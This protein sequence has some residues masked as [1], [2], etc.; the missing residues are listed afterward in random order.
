MIALVTTLAFAQEV[1]TVDE[2][3]LDRYA[4]TWYELAHFPEWFQR[5]C[6]ATTATYTVR[7]DGLLDVE[8]RCRRGSLEGRETVAYGVAR[9]PDPEE[10]GKLEV[11]FFRPIWSDY[12]VVD[13]DPDY[14]WAIVGAPDR[15][16]L[17]F[18]SRTP[19]VAPEVYDDLLARAEDAGFDTTRLRIPEQP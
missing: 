3:D 5:N 8:N 7:R 19:H 2:L 13:L 9:Q 10:P 11:S 18:L 6:H 17:W 4:G 12:W 15:D 1:P 14:Q 16:S